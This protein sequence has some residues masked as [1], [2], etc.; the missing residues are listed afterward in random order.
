MAFTML[1]LVA[2]VAGACT[3]SND[4]VASRQTVTATA[5]AL[6]LAS[7]GPLL[8]TIN[9]YGPE[10]VGAPYQRY[11][12]SAAISPREVL[13]QATAG[14]RSNGFRLKA[15]SGNG[16]ATWVSA[17]HGQPVSVSVRVLSGGVRYGSVTVPVGHVGVDVEVIGRTL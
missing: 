15:G 1:L 11:V 5:N 7:L 13:R 17:V 2:I 9:N 4:G 14:L 8:L 10:A 16:D 12:I 3:S 6:R